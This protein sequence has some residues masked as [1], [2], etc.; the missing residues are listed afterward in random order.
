M[1]NGIDVGNSGYTNLK[2]VKV[3]P[4]YKHVS[5][6]KLNSTGEIIYQAQIYKYNWSK[7]FKCDREAA[8][9]ADIK[10]SQ[11]GFDPVNILKKKI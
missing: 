4:K 9:A 2:Y 5:V 10:L 8:K 7:Y 3:H 1:I 11:K 6:Y